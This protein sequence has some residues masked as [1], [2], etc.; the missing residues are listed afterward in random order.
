MFDAW[1]EVCRERTDMV[2]VLVTG[3]EQEIVNFVNLTR[4]GLHR[5]SDA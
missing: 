1:P 2:G 5:A 4:S 3:H